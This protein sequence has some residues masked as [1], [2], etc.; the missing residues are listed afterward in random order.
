MHIQHDMNFISDRIVPTKASLVVDSQLRETIVSSR[1]L[2]LVDSLCARHVHEKT[3][4]DTSIA[5]DR[6]ILVRRLLPSFEINA[7]DS[8]IDLIDL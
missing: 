5:I 1:G 8:G 4:P 3:G 2:V 6:A 7:R